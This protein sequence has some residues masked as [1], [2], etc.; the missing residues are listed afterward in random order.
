VAGDQPIEQMADRGEPLLDARR[1]ELT[2]AGLDPGRDMHRLHGR[3]RRHA[4]IRAPAEKFLRGAGIGPARVRVADVCGEEFEETHTGFAFGRGAARHYP[5]DVAPFSAIAE[6]TASAYGDLAADLPPGIEAH[7]FRPTDEAAPSG[8]ERISA[9][10]I[11]QMVA[12][13]TMPEPAATDSIVPLGEADPEEVVALAEAARPGPLGRRT[14]LLGHYVGVRR[15]GRLVAMAGERFRLQGHVELSA[16]CFHPEW[17]GVGFGSGLTRYLAHRARAHGEIPFLHVF[18]ENAAMRVYARLGFRERARLWVLWR[19]PQG[20]DHRDGVAVV[21]PAPSG[22]I[23]PCPQRRERCRDPIHPALVLLIDKTGFVVAAALVGVGM[24]ATI[25]PL[26]GRFLGPTPETKGVA[27]DGEASS[28]RVQDRQPQR[29]ARPLRALFRDRRF[30]TLSAGFALGFF[31]Q[32]GLVTHLVERL[33]PVLGAREPR[34]RSAPLPSARFPGA[35]S[36]EACWGAP[37]TV[38]RRRA[39]SR[40]KPVAWRFSR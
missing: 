31:A 26:A 37:I 8:W 9:R 40:C 20:G 13:G 16:I 39:I 36:S 27:P 1:G 24:T 2:R 32:I 22:R 7:L 23:E 11:V 6:P 38:W 5:S 25:W 34:R 4:R 35:S 29:Q 14:V 10:P 19:R 12:D 3:N 28:Q 18:P 15:D 17:R 21:R 33:A 30:A